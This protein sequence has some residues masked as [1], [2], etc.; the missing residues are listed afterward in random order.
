MGLS[1][2]PQPHTYQQPSTAVDLIT[3]FV[4]TL[5]GRAKQM[6]TGAA[7][8]LSVKVRTH[9]AKCTCLRKEL[10]DGTFVFSPLSTVIDCSILGSPA[11]GYVSYVGWTTISEIAEFMCDTGYTAAADMTTNATCQFPGGWSTLPT[12]CQS[13]LSPTKHTPQTYRHGT[14]TYVHIK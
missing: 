12:Y 2:H 6:G 3:F 13:E 4:G 9:A 1:A 7:E 11:N 10:N 8:S 5:H 14:F